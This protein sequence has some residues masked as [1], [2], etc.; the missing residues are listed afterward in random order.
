LKAG[1]ILEDGLVE[2]HVVE[3]SVVPKVRAAE[4]D[5]VE[6]G[7]TIEESRAAELDA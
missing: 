6:E 7:C 2:G 1:V 3:I 5:R 4:I